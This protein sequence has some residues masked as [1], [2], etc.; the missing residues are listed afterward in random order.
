[1]AS[2]PEVQKRAQEELDAFVGPDRLPTV[3]DKP[4]LPYVAALVKE[5][6]RWRSV[7]PLAVPHLSTEED[8]YNGYRIPKG[9]IV[10]ANTWYGS[11]QDTQYGVITNGAD[12]GPTRLT[13]ATTPI[14]QI[15]IRRGFWWTES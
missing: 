13:L 9:S 7:V 4:G 15:L 5:C 1:M 8:E 3:E 10:V 14:L 12:A 2:H 11:A 6:F